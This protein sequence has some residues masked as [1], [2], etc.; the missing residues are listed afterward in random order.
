MYKWV[1]KELFF[2]ATLAFVFVA[3]AGVSSFLKNHLHKETA[4]ASTSIVFWPDNQAAIYPER[5]PEAFF[6]AQKKKKEAITLATAQM[7][8]MAH[9]KISN[10]VSG[11]GYR[12]RPRVTRTYPSYKKAPK[13]RSFRKAA[14][15]PR[16][17]QNAAKPAKPAS[18]K[19]SVQK[20]DTLAIRAHDVHM[21]WVKKTLAEYRDP[22]RP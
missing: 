18:K 1:Q 9:S 19:T 4:L 13:K 10:V 22:N 21:K 2:F 20:P 14:V 3:A 12:A 7:P 5:P 15:T 11:A 16:S 8:A 17:I 6:L